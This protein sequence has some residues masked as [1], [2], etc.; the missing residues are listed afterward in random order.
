MKK[1]RKAEGKKMKFKFV[2][3]KEGKQKKRR[4]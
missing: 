3:D 4:Q 2:E 1:K